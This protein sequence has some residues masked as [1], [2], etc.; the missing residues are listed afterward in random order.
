MITH[1]HLKRYLAAVLVCFAAILFAKL[2]SA[3]VLWLLIAVTI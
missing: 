2:F 3:P 1:I